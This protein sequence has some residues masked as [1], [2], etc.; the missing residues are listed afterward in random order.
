MSL[1]AACQLVC[2]LAVVALLPVPASAQSL[3]LGPRMSF[4]RG[5][6]PSSTSSTRLLGGTLRMRSSKH[7]VFEAALDYRSEFSEDRTTR[8]RQ[9]PVQASLLV[10]PVRATFSPY[11]LGGIG[12]Y[13]QSTDTLG[14]AGVVLGTSVERKTG[15]HL[16]LGAELFVARHAALF[17]DYRWR[18]VKFGAPDPEGEPINIPGLKRLELSHRGSMWT[19]GMAFYF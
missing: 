11:L 16:G 1:R 13:S 4:V 15:W 2:A 8:V 12:V 10:F 9:T 19:S 6:L 14:P 18:F 5:D 17:A 7:M 3:G